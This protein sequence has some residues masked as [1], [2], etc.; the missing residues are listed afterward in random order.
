MHI[1]MLLFGLLS[2]IIIYCVPACF[3]CVFLE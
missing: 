3:L 2:P 1:W